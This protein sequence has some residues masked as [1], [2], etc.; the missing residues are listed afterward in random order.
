MS[1]RSFR[2]GK[3]TSNR[4]V[5]FEIGQ[6]LGLLCPFDVS[7]CL[8][9]PSNPSV[10]KAPRLPDQPGTPI[11]FPMVASPVSWGHPICFCFVL[12]TVT[13]M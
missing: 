8:S 3:A 12:A 13:S 7:L 6:T 10:H 9:P 5:V 1:A 11:H 4:V 2:P